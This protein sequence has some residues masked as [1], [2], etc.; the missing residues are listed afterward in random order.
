MQT[1]IF[2]SIAIGVLVGISVLVVSKFIIT[3]LI[4]AVFFRMATRR[5]R[6]MAYHFQNSHFERQSKRIMVDSEFYPYHQP[7]A[8]AS[9]TIEID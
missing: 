8:Q 5:K 6:Q 1:S 7:S 4:L 3:F 2:K 9:R